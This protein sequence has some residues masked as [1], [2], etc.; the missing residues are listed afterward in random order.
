MKAIKRR[1]F[2]QIL[3]AAVFA[4]VLT[5]VIGKAPEKC[6]PI[7]KMNISLPSWLKDFTDCRKFTNVHLKNISTQD[8]QF[9]LEFSD[10][11]SVLFDRDVTP[12]KLLELNHGFSSKKYMLLKRV[13]SN[14]AYKKTGSLDRYQT[15]DALNHLSINKLIK[16]LC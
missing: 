13:L 11:T 8:N 14:I 6:L 16:D 5:K 12:S 15:Q 4:S 3:V 2:I 9:A 10:K 7:S 1:N